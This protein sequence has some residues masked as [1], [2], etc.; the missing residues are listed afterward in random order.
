MFSLF[1]ELFLLTLDY[2]FE[3][4]RESILISQLKFSL[5]SGEVSQE[6]P[7]RGDGHL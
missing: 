3:Y 1:A 2:L 7:G 6:P 5:F 4:N